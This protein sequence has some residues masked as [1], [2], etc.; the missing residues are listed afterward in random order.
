MS[1]HGLLTTKMPPPPNPVETHD[2]G[3]WQSVEAALRTELPVDYKEELE[4]GQRARTGTGPILAAFTSAT[5]S[6]IRRPMHCG[7][8][9]MPR[10]VISA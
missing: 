7:T 1:F 5:T 10:L 8:D 4:R 3:N 9:P 2:T 6:V